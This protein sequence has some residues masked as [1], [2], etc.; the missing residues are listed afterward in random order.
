MKPRRVV[1]TI[2]VETSLT[3][4]NLKRELEWIEDEGGALSNEYLKIIQLQA[5][6]IKTKKGKRGNDNRKN[7]K[8]MENRC[9]KVRH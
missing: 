1:L 9:T 6:V 8:K 5:N 3:I 4:K 7:S 2:E